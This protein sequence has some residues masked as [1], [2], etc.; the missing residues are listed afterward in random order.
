MPGGKPIW[1]G[2]L[3]DQDLDNLFG[4]IEAHVVCP[5]TI[6]RPFLPYRDN[7]TKTLLFPTGNFVGGVCIIAKS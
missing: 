2:N 4:F 5:S 3:E 1:H 6:S 7:R